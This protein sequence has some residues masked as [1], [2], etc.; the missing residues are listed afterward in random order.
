MSLV[1]KG[2]I[3]KTSKCLKILWPQLKLSFFKFWAQI[4]KL[5]YFSNLSQILP[6]PYFEGAD[7]KSDICISKFW[8]HGYL[9]PKCINFQILTKFRMYPILKVLISIL[10]FVFKCQAWISKFRHFGP[11]SI[12]FLFLTKFCLYPIL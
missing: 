9:G 1:V 6:V 5:G 2:K 11:K 7:F 12:N 10:P 8:D 3:G 4:P